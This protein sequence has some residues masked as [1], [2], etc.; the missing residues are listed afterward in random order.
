VI[1]EKKKFL[2]VRIPKTAGTT[3]SFALRERD[4]NDVGAPKMVLGINPSKPETKRVPDYTENQ[5]KFIFLL[6]GK[7]GPGSVHNNYKQWVD[8][9]P[10]AEEY[11]TFS[12]VRNPW[13]W[14]FSLYNFFEKI[15]MHKRRRLFSGKAAARTEARGRM[16]QFEDMLGLFDISLNEFVDNP[17]AITFDKFVNVYFS[18]DSYG[19]TQSSFLKNVNGGINLDFIGRFEQLQEDWNFI[20]GKVGLKERSLNDTNRNHFPKRDLKKYLESSEIKTKIIEGL[21]EDFENFNYSTNVFPR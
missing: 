9:F 3:L 7:E 14:V 21:A 5:S 1:D 11:F 8:R 12:F 2:F 6:G 17:E 20:A 16:S 18:S 19:K 10:K 4:F 13:G 15:C